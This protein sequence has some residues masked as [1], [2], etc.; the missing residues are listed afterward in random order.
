MPDSITV[1]DRTSGWSQRITGSGADAG[2]E[3]AWVQQAES[4]TA[5]AKTLTTEIINHSDRRRCIAVEYRFELDHTDYL[6]LLAGVHPT[7]G[8]PQDGDLAYAYVREENS[9]IRLGIPFA[10]LASPARNIGMSVAADLADHPVLPFQIRLRRTADQTIVII[11]RNQIRLEPRA[12]NKVVLYLHEHEGDHRA[13]LAWM[14]DTWPA[15]FTVPAGV[16]AEHLWCTWTGTNF[17]EKRYRRAMDLESFF[18]RGIVQTRNRNWLGANFPEQERWLLG[19]DQKWHLLQHKTELPDHPGKDATV[20]AISEFVEN[21][22]P[23][24]ELVKELQTRKDGFQFWTWDWYTHAGVRDHMDRMINQGLTWHFYF[25]PNDIWKPWAR[26]KYPQSLYMPDSYDSYVD[27]T[28]LDPFPGSAWAQQLVDDARSIF[29]TYPRCSGLFLDQVYYDLNNPGKDDGVSIRPDAQPFSR[30]QWNLYRTLKEIRKLADQHGRTL[31]AN[32]IFNSLEIA[33]L[34]DFGLL[35]GVDPLQNVAQFYDIG[36]RMHLVQIMDEPTAQ[37]CILQG[38]QSGIFKVAGQDE[39]DRSLRPMLGRLYAPMMILFQDRSVVLEPHCLTLPAGFKGNVFRRPDGNLLVTVVTPGVGHLSPYRWRNLAVR[40]RLA[41]AAKVKRIYQLSTDRLGPVAVDFHRNGNEI[42]VNLPEH[43]SGSMLVLGTGGKFVSMKESTI[44]RSAEQEKVLFLDNLDEGTREEIRVA[45]RPDSSGK[46]FM[47]AEYTPADDTVLPVRSVSMDG[48]PDFEW[49]MTTPV[50]IDLAPSARLVEQPHHREHDFLNPGTLAVAVGETTQVQLTLQN[51]KN[52][53]DVITLV[54]VGEN[55]QV[56][57]ANISMHL[58][59]GQVAQIYLNVTGER[60][61]PGEIQVGSG[62]IARQLSIEVFGTS[63]QGVRHDKV[64]QVAVCLDSIA[65]GNPRAPI[66]LNGVKC[67]SL[68]QRSSTSVWDFRAKHVLSV[69]PGTLKTRNV[70]EIGTSAKTFQV[71]SPM[72]K[73]TL[74][75][76][77]TYRLSP[78]DATPQSTPPQWIQAAGRRVPNGE[79]MKWTFE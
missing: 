62:E 18:D 9:W 35:E 69:A 29:T 20:D 54:A 7:P 6:P 30:H 79:Q 49:R 24:D 43:R 38:W 15:L 32:F 41:S 23:T 67:G 65:A 25:N 64:K 55:F 39:H 22:K 36:N 4:E 59:P 33:S 10:S 5:S 2:A 50:S 58:Q 13:G 28:V 47:L 77:R 27:T 12:K 44:R 31:H 57:P 63:L 71:A 16:G 8:W 46:R 48:K 75:N 76:G 21:L 60:T 56:K 68:E 40:L 61:G 42:L 70:L 53:A 37:T 1:S 66:F 19:I 72:L 52:R 14:R 11:N 74:E 17:T 26:A 3:I 73:V 51:H 78:S 45:V 34:T